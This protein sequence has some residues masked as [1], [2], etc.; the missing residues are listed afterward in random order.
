MDAVI[1]GVPIALGTL[2]GL[3]NLLLLVNGA[4][5][6]FTGRP[7]FL[8]RLLGVR[9][10][11]APATALD[12]AMEGAA[13]VL[14]SVGLVVGLGAVFI[15]FIASSLELT[16]ASQQLAPG[17]WRAVFYPLAL[18]SLTLGALCCGVSLALR[19]RV[20]YVNLVGGVVAPAQ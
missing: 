13:L 19:T 15:P 1:R 12:Y 2:F 16:G 6:V 7:A 14:W 20:K 8:Q 9:R 5:Q 10:R 11:R 3:A 18:A 4:Y 17:P